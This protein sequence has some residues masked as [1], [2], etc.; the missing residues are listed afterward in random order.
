MLLTEKEYKEEVQK[1]AREVK[2]LSFR[3][4]MV[5]IIVHNFIKEPA[6]YILVLQHSD[7]YIGDLNWTVYVDWEGDYS[8]EDIFRSMALAIFYRDVKDAVFNCWSEEG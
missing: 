7:T 8:E 2:D 3:G 5:R 1:V 4:A 6:Y